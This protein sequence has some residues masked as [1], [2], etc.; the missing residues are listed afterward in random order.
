M[1]EDRE[2]MMVVRAELCRRLEHLHGLSGRRGARE[3]D[4]RLE[5]IR[6]LAAGY[7]LRPAASVAEA[8]QAS[9]IRPGCGAAPYLERLR[10]AIGCERADDDAVQ[11][12][13]ASISLR[14][15]A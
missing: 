8:L 6:A 2:A 3:F 10:D 11:A 14:L 15:G 5:G 13:L 12:M 4:L 1:R 7:G 9:G